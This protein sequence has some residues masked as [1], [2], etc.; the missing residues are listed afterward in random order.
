MTASAPFATSL[1]ERVATIV[2][3]RA[4]GNWGEYAALPDG[5]HG[6][7]ADGVGFV[8]WTGAGG[9]SVKLVMRPWMVA[10][11]RDLETAI[12]MALNP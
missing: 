3:C 8:V 1:A 10:C 6:V 4:S 5:R 11:D 12:G 7:T 2:N 9:W